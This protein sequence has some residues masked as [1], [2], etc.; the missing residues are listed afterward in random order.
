M[1]FSDDVITHLV[2]R[3]VSVVTVKS[4]DF[5]LWS[6][7]VIE[8]RQQFSRFVKSDHVLL[9]KRPKLY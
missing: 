7:F 2:Q 9:D 6:S 3:V 5:V 4:V 8:F 1:D